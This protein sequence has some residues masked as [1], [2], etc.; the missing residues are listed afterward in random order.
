MPDAADPAAARARRRALVATNAGAFFSLSLMQIVGLVT[1]LWTTKL[2]IE[3]A[4]IGFI[5]SARSVLPFLLSIQL[6]GL[7][8]AIGVRKVMLACA[9]GGIALPLLY[10]LLPHVWPLIA[11]Q[12]VLGLVSAVS[13]LGS[14]A[15]IGLL[16]HGDPRTMGIF[17]FLTNLGSVLGPLL[18]GLAWDHLGP[19]GGFGMVSLWSAGLLASTLAMPRAIPSAGR[20]GKGLPGPE[21]YL[22]AFR[23]LGRT[24]VAFVIC[25]TFLRIALITMQESFYPVHLTGVGISAA[26]IGVLVSIAWLSSTPSTLLIG[27]AIRLLGSAEAVLAASVALSTVAITVTPALPGFWPLAAAA[28]LF[29]IGQGLGFPLTI[30]ILSKDV[31]VEEQG[32]SAGLRATANRFAAVV[33]PLAMGAVA[34][35]AGLGASFWVLG[36]ALIAALV[37][38]VLLFGSRRPKRRQGR[39]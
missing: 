36:G 34:Q 32:V 4:W 25:M 35:A 11:L 27:P 3:P 31:G 18:L 26:Q 15:S 30:S 2:A 9:A 16:V 10:P 23:L 7:M 24:L 22:R 29:G 37:L 17:S 5:L 39:G 19:V 33:V 1:P 28:C 13:W 38:C 8:D 6:G 12:L 20:G 21:V 14:Q